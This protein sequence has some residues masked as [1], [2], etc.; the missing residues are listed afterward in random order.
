MKKKII[1]VVVI[2]LLLF[3]VVLYVANQGQPI[4]AKFYNKTRSVTLV[5]SD[6]RKIELP[7]AI[8]VSSVRYANKDESFVFWN[9]G[10]MAFIDEKGKS[11]FEDCWAKNNPSGSPQPSETRL[12]NPASTNCVEKGG[13]SRIRTKPDGSQY[14]LCFFDDNRAGEEWAMLRGECPVSGR[15][16]TGYDT[17]VQKY[18]AWSGGQ[19]LAVENAIC[20]FTNGSTCPD[21]G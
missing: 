14:S 18:C 3:S 4:E 13:Q 11:T 9:K 17:E 21:E 15:K 2:G 20:T 10:E 19:T 16:T 1:L 5:L 8:S 12:A 6:G 7:Q